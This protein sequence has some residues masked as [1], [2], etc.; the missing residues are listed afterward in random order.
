MKYINLSYFKPLLSN[1]PTIAFMKI[2]ID[3]DCFFVSAA[4]IQ[5]PSLEF[6]PVAIGGR[7]DTKIFNKDAKKQAVNFENSGSFVPTFYKAYEERDD[8]IDAFKDED[9]R[10]R[11]ILTTSSYE[12]RAY[13]VKTAMSIK[14]ALSL[15][16]HLI[17]KAPDMSLYQKLSHE[18]HEFL[19][20]KIP[21]VE[22][23]SIDE[24]YGDL[25][26]WVDDSDVPNFIAALRDEIK[27]VT[28]LPVSI[29]AAKTRYIAKLSTTYAKP[30]GCR[31]IFENELESFIE[32]IPVTKFAGIGKSMSEK[33]LDAQ[34]HTLGELSKR[35]GTIESWGPYAKELYLRVCGLSD[36]DITTK[37]IRKSIGISRTFDP[38]RD[39]NELRR[40]V[41]VLARHLSFAIL[42]L[43][44]IPTV[45]HLSLN[46]EMSQKSHKNIS[47]CEIFTEKKF[48]SLCLK[49]FDEADVHKRLHLIR[50]SINCS[51]FT[52]E[53]RKELSL[54]G[55]EE[56]QKMYRLTNHSQEIR[57][58]YGI[59]MLKWGSEL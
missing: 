16:P 8:D 22:Q 49:L 25:S 15:C 13:G 1:L 5:E 37:H 54:I 42:K 57:E 27:S 38:L 35:R 34:I 14:E 29:G 4:R 50:M 53:S 39:R 52:R 9:G 21:L 55:F 30:F 23:A 31:V 56:D 36:D 41:H 33:L 47:L 7:S 6:K 44:V 45:F 51:S 10:V 2:H 40:R 18:L 17:I 19:Q 48:D 20:T 11:G 26:G 24:F 12:A 43:K 46:Y 3:I 28:K 58:K 59:D 32:K